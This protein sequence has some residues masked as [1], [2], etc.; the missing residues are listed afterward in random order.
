[1]ELVCS[2]NLGVHKW[3]FQAPYIML[4]EPEKRKAGHPG[5]V[6]FLKGSHTP[7]PNS[8]ESGKLCLVPGIPGSC[9]Y[10]FFKVGIYDISHLTGCWLAI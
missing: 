6:C 1:M 10:T 5:W 2:A 9:E 8:K 7:A 4:L 3:A